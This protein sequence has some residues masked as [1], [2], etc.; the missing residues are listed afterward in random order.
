MTW[1][2]DG[3][4]VDPLAQ[5]PEDGTFL[6]GDRPSQPNHYQECVLR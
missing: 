5:P 4:N 2:W 3:L 1:G 6:E